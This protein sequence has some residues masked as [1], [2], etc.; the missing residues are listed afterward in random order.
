MTTIQRAVTLSTLECA[1][2]QI[3]FAVPS[4]FMSKRK[5]DHGEFYCPVGH[6]NY[7]PNESQ[8]ERLARQFE[9]ERARRLREQQEHDQTK[10]ELETTEARRR[11]EKAAKTRLKNKIAKGQCPYCNCT[12]PNLHEHMKTEHPDCSEVE[13]AT[14]AGD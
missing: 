7:Y 4:S 5:D 14:S 8:A 11:A 3:A 10:A 12:F 1:R 2:C 13:A 9:E 6:T